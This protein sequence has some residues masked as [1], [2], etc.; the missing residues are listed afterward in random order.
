V[1]IHRLG[2]DIMEDEK[3]NQIMKLLKVMMEQIEE[4]KKQ[5]DKLK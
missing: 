1:H 2:G 4:I 3:F 5:I